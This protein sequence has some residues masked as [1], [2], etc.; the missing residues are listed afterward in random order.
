MKPDANQTVNAILGLGGDAFKW[1][2]DMY[3]KCCTLVYQPREEGHEEGAPPSVASCGSDGSA[4]LLQQVAPGDEEE[5]SVSEVSDGNGSDAAVE[6]DGP[7]Q[8]LDDLL[9]Q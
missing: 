9:L 5:D 7:I 2:F 1:V 3:D 8:L 6:D 4:H